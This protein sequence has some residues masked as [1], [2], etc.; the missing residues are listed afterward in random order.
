M[1]D[2]VKSSQE[3]RN[4]KQELDDLD[5]FFLSMSKTMKK[6]PRLDQIRIKM[7]LLK[8]ISEAEIKP[9][10]SQKNVLRTTIAIRSDRSSLN[11]HNVNSTSGNLVQPHISYSSSSQFI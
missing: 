6:L 3:N 11:R 4:K 9:L 8:A 10:E 5:T 2:M 1:M 7:D